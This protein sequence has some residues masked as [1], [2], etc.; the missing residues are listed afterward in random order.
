MAESSVARLHTLADTPQTSGISITLQGGLNPDGFI[1]QY[2]T[3]AYNQPS[4]YSNK[5]FV[6]PAEDNTVPWSNPTSGDGAIASDQPRGDQPVATAI[7][8]RGY[9][10]GYAPAPDPSAVCATVFVPAAGQHDPATWEYSSLVITVPYVG[11][12]TISVKYTGLFNYD[13]AANKN[14]IGVWRQ[15]QVRYSGDAM[16][17]KTITNSSESGQLFIGGLDLRAG[18][19]YSVGY[20]MQPTSKATGRTSLAAQAS[21]TVS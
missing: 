4:T 5:I 20:F 15:K 6:W 2:V 9:I 12:D 1:A 13:P 8:K 21:F 18:E 17:T 11:I 7:Q 16:A 3:F 19:T 10:L 14:W